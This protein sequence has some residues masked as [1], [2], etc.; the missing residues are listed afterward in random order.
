MNRFVYEVV[1]ANQ[2][3]EKQN[4]LLKATF[5]SLSDG[6]ISV[7]LDGNVTMMNTL[8]EKMTG[9]KQAEAVGQP[10]DSVFVVVGEGKDCPLNDNENINPDSYTDL[11]EFHYIS[12][13]KFLVHRS[14][15]LIAIEECT[16]PIED[17]MGA[18]YGKVV[19]FR[20]VTEKND[21]IKHIEYLS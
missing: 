19:V 3:L 16:A 8:A 15:H 11:P 4:E 17:D 13:E 21:R 7:D 20:D 12:K 6:V 14:K 5:L 18:I 2:N 10:F 9:W 1:K